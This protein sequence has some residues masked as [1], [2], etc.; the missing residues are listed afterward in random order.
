VGIR[1]ARSA[2]LSRVQ[3]HVC[4]FA[5]LTRNIR[6]R[7]GEKVAINV[8]IFVDEH[9]PRPFVEDFAK[10][11]PSANVAEA[12]AAA[13]PD[14]IYMDAMG[15]GMG[16]C[17][18]QT[19]FQVGTPRLSNERRAGQAVNQGEAR[20]LYDQLTP[21]TPILLALSASTPIFRGSSPSRRL[22]SQATSPTWTV[23]G[24]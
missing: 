22:S 11:V 14:H 1:G 20:W 9:T 4:R 23:A 13:L 3:Y 7:R 8:P 15:F 16:C 19:T 24:T 17:C 10:T 12:T 6:H 2:F 18:L 21:I 5:N